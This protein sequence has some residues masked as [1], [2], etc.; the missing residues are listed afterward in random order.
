M[1]LRFLFMLVVLEACSVC[2]GA[3]TNAAGTSSHTA[4]A[5]STAEVL[6]KIDQLVEQNKALENQNQKLV[7]EIEVLRRSLGKGNSGHAWHNGNRNCAC[8]GFACY[9]RTF[10]TECT[11]TDARR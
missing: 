9:R 1:R 3:Q 7:E 8:D 11:T 10:S 4:E 6:N 5:Q 2:P